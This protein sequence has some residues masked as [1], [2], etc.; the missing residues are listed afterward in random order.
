MTYN[1]SSLRFSQILH[2]STNLPP[3][4]NHHFTIQTMPDKSTRK[5]GVDTVRYETKNPPHAI[6]VGNILYLSNSNLPLSEIDAESMPTEEFEIDQLQTSLRFLKSSCNKK[7]SELTQHRHQGEIL[8]AED[9][10]WLDNNGNL[11]DKQPVIANGY[12]KY[13]LD[14]KQEKEAK[15]RKINSPKPKPKTTNARSTSVKKKSKISS[16]NFCLATI[17]QKIEVINWYK[18]N[19]ESQ[20]KT[21]E[22]F[23]KR[24]PEL[25]LK[26]PTLSRWIK[27]ETK[28]KATAPLNAQTALRVRPVKHSDIEEML[29]QW[30]DEAAAA[31]VIVTGDVIKAQWKDF[32]RKKNLPEDQW[33]QVSDGW[34]T[35]F[36][37]RHNMQLYTNH[38]EA[39]SVDIATVENEIKRV[40]EI[41]KDYKIMDIYN[42][43]ETALFYAYVLFYYHT[44]FIV[45]SFSSY[46]HLLAFQYAT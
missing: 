8:A 46:L 7:V 34:L 35:R 17:A 27:S 37:T 25:N 30:L 15:K 13:V 33:L 45:S 4:Q 42:M 26:Q 10:E 28:I 21:V 29:E 24:L 23:S 31:G 18:A 32:A 5:F 1:L 40:Q 9:E 6:C 12:E 11:V 3:L 2:V 43:D 44:H 22:Y 36:K 41:N 19:G 20:R 39:G 14:R 38:G 16:K